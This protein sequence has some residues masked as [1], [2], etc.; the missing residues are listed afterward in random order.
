[1]PWVLIWLCSVD[2]PPPP[3]YLMTVLWCAVCGMVWCDM[4]CVMQTQASK[5]LRIVSED[6][7]RGAVI[8]G[9]V[10]ETVTNGTEL[11]EVL[12]RGEASR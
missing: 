6:A 2:V 3:R 12:R 7:V 11:M 4:D 9:L 10:E 1:M 8:G 5:N